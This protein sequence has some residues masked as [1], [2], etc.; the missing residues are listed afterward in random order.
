MAEMST[1]YLCAGETRIW[2]AC[3]FWTYDASFM[4]TCM[5]CESKCTMTDAKA[6]KLM[7]RKRYVL[8]LTKL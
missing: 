8:P 2:Y 5:V 7:K 6:A 1:S 4:I 3:F